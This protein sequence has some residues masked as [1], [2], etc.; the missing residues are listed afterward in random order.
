L[1]SS[2]SHDLK[3]P[4]VGIIGSLSTLEQ[5]GDGLPSSER[6]ELVN[7]ARTE[8][9]RLH[10]IIHNLLELT[11]LE[12]GHLQ[13]NR[14][15]AEIG[16]LISNVERR[17]QRTY[18]NFNLTL[19][20]ATEAEVRV[21]PLLLEQVLYNL[22]DNAIKYSGSTALEMHVEDTNAESVITL[23]DHGK[24]IPEE[25][26]ERVFDKF[27]RLEQTDKRTAGS[28]LGLAICRAIVRAHGGHIKLG[29]RKDS[30]SGLR[31]TITLPHQV[32]PVKTKERLA[33]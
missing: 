19:G 9:E 32:N 2:V 23:E 7:S 18:P 31:V 28:G 17:V 25:F 24:G 3:T 26:R 8:A 29:E 5:V 13:P 4:L 21:D 15:T 33:A 14:E 1:L 11:K 6:H 20:G 30:T 12:S 22:M 16:P 10:H 27:Y